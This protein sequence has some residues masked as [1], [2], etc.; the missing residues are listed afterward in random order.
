MIRER[1]RV[2]ENML[3]LSVRKEWSFR[4]TALTDILYLIPT[5][6]SYMRRKDASKKNNY[7][8]IRHR[9]PYPTCMLP[10]ILGFV[11]PVIL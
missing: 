10:S 8:F 5:A 3:P 9:I 7:F 11:P 4:A 2:K 6:T 1:Y